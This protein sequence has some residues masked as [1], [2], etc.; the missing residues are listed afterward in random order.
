M[1]RYLT[2]AVNAICESVGFDSSLAEAE[3]GMPFGRGAAECLRH[4]LALAEKMG[5]ETKNYDNYVGEVCFGHGAP[6]AVLAHLD[7]VPAGQGWDTNPFEAVIKDGKIYGRGTTDDK[8]PAIAALFAMKALKD[9]GFEPNKRIKL[10]VGCNEEC[11]WAC[12]EHYKKV[13][14]LPD[15][16]FSPDA[17]FPVIYAEKGIAHVKFSFPVNPALF[18]DFRGGDRAN[19]VC[20]YCEAKPL[21]IN[22]E[23]ANALGISVEKDLLVS[24]GKSAHGSTPEEGKNAIEPLLTY[25]A[26]DESVKR[27]LNCLFR[28]E[29]RLKEIKDETGF[30]TL[31]P[32]VVEY[33]RPQKY[34]QNGTLR[35]LTDIRYPATFTLAELQG[36]LRLFGVEYEMVSHQAPLYHEKDSELITTLCKVYEQFSGVKS[37]PIAIGGGTYARALKFGVAFGPEIEGE[38][39]TIHQANEYITIDRIALMLNVYKEALKRLTK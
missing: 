10:I 15:V 38:E 7:V 29:Y 2:Q 20:D 21:F 23:R 25:F 9:E 22:P 32:D 35:I 4:F 11:G 18:D 31:S 3:E 34:S 26:D 13:A 27:V 14:A 17:N 12:I 24:R 16:G 6:F 33:I 1:E 19:M 8:G 30:L 39:V 28:D 36:K 5:F 37:E